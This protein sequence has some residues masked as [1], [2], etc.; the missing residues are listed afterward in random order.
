VRIIANSAVTEVIQGPQERETDPGPLRPVIKTPEGK[1]KLR[2]PVPISYFRRVAPVVEEA[3]GQR[4][5]GCPLYTTSSPL[6]AARI[7][8]AVNLLRKL[9]IGKAQDDFVRAIP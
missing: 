5:T 7:S 3:E 8:G 9:H 2:P 1:L 4:E 6:Y